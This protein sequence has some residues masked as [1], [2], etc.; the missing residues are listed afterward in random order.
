MIANC[1]GFQTFSLSTMNKGGRAALARSKSIDHQIDEDRER[2]QREVQLLILGKSPLD[3]FTPLTSQVKS[4]LV[5]SSQVKSSQVK[6][7]QVK[8]SQI[9]LDSIQRKTWVSHVDE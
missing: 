1:F 2:R 9:L 4:S 5:K 6:S 7:S 3:P 8:S